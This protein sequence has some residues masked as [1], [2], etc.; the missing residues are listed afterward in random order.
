MNDASMKSSVENWKVL[1]LMDAVSKEELERWQKRVITG[2]QSTGLT[3]DDVKDTEL[4]KLAQ[5]YAPGLK[6]IHCLLFNIV[7]GHETEMHKDVGEWVV[8]F[9]P[10]S[11]PTGPLR[12][13]VDGLVSDIS[14]EENMM[15]VLDCTNIPHQQMVPTDGSTRFSVAFK[16]RLPVGP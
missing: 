5:A 12:V 3:E 7:A 6:L 10:Y 11:C 15:V 9:Y 16:F 13:E 14:V 2:T 4:F 8:L 1:I